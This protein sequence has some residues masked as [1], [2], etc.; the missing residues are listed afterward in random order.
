MVEYSLALIISSCI[1]SS[2]R[3]R[4]RK[5]LKCSR[6][7]FPKREICAYFEF[8]FLFSP[9]SLSFLVSSFFR[10]FSVVR[11]WAKSLPRLDVQISVASQEAQ[12]RASRSKPQ[13]WGPSLSLKALNFWPESLLQGTNL[14]WGPQLRLALVFHIETIRFFLISHELKPLP[15]SL[16]HTHLLR[17]IWY[18]LP[19]CPDSETPASRL[20][21]QPWP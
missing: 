1:F 18:R 21:S 6:V 2:R 14:T 19:Q 20:K 8:S 7:Q 17:G 9:F 12:I 11:F 5:K 15:L 13:F 16:S 4:T 3:V 10:S